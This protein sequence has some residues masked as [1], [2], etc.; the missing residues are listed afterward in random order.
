MLKGHIDP[1]IWCCHPTSVSGVLHCLSNVENFMCN[2]VSEEIL[3]LRLVGRTQP[4]SR[5]LSTPLFCVPKYSA[6]LGLDPEADFANQP[7]S[8]R[9]LGSAVFVIL[10]V[11][12]GF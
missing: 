8:Q 3:I 6:E 11:H 12:L 7:G 1:L 2:I 10:Q 4:E 5:G 9:L